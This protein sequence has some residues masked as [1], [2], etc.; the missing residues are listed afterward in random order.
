[1][2]KPLLSSDLTDCVPKWCIDY[3]SLLNLEQIT[4]MIIVANYLDIEPLLD[5]CCVSVAILIQCKN[6]E[7]LKTILNIVN[8][9][10]PVDVEA[11]INE[12]N[13]WCQEK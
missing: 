13:K 3:M 12:E 2:F 9:F 8:D 4:N 11:Q 6:P 7:Q 1:M 5:L 10:T